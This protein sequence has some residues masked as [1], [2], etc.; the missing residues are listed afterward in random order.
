PSAL[1][2]V[3]LAA[4]A[5]LTSAYGAGVSYN[6]VLTRAAL[7]L[8]P[9]RQS[10]WCGISINSLGFAGLVLCKTKEEQ[11]LLDNVGVLRLLTHV[12]FPLTPAANT[13]DHALSI[14]DVKDQ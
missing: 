11:D 9:R 13:D 1:V 2:T 5:K 12:G 7:L 10:S 6:M 3:Y 14:S 4:L 8:F